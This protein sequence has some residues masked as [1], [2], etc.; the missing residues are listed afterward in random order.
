MIVAPSLLPELPALLVIAEELHFGRAAERL[1][2]SQSRVSQIVR[3]IE[4]VVG[5]K[6]FFRRPHVRLTP[7]GELLT[8]AARHALSELHDSI[9]RAADVACGRGGTVRIGYSPVAMLT[10]LPSVLK[11]FRSR[12]P[13][14]AMQFHEAYSADLWAALEDGRLDIVISRE[15]R[16]RSGTRT[17]LFLH[18][19]LVAVLPSDDPLAKEN[20]LEVATLRNRDFV[21]IDESISPQWHQAIATFC[22]AAGFDPRVSQKVNDWT[23]TLAL[24][25]SGLGV[26]I[27]SSTL[28]KLS[29]PGVEFVPLVEG[30][31][32]GSFWITYPEAATDPAVILLG[33]ELVDASNSPPLG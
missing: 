23:A 13:R 33:A 17:H 3:R 22:Q 1:N 8:K 4:D 31:D 32:A 19:N 28:A 5:Y 21:A 12:N 10:H 20:S 27:V 11:S 14:V 18:D 26:S 24:V 29:F 9:V 7:A 2:V 15:A 16:L 30:A 25:A 6:V